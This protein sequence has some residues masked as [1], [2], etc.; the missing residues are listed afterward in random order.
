[1][2]LIPTTTL[3]SIEDMVHRSNLDDADGDSEFTNV[4]ADLEMNS[5]MVSYRGRFPFL[6]SLGVLLLAV[7]ATRPIVS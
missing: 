4:K 1:M 6:Q 7:G 2:S 3:L 5:T